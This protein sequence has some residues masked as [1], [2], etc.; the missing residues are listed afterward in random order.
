MI[1]RHVT[2]I[3]AFT[4]IAIACLSMAIPSCG[5]NQ[6]QTTLHAS[7]VSLN[8]AREAFAVWTEK[9]QDDLIAGKTKAEA[10]AAVAEYRSSKEEVVVISFGVVYSALALAATQNDDASMKSALEQADRLLAALKKI[11]VLK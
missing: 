9:H 11:G 2:T 7:V 4:I 8:A 10:E 1:R 3:T 6:R 5:A